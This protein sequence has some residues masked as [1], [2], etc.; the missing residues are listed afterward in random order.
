MMQAQCLCGETI[1]N[2]ELK[3]H[4][5]NVCHCQF[6]RT[7]TSGIMMS[8]DVIQGSLEFVKQD[9]LKV[10]NSSEWGERGFCQNCGTNLF[11]R[12]KDHRY[13]NINVF[14]LK[15]LPSDLRLTTEVYIDKKP[16]FY[17]FQNVTNKL[18]EEDIIA[19]FPRDI[20]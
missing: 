9:Q 19:L 15:D 11:W 3:D 10:Y 16:D 20:D 7:Q 17:N 8:I 13:A 12:T 6:C 14:A 2:V 1:F 4:D 18:T 5:V